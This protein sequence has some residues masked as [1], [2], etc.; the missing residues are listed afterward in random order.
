M[1]IAL[2]HVVLEVRDAE[3]TAA[4][5]ADLL[6]LAPVRMD[7]WRRGEAPFPSGRVTDETIIDYFPPAMWRNRRRAAN[8]NHLCFTL[9]RQGV[10]AL[11][12]KLARR[13]IPIQRESKR[14]YGAR[15]WG[16]SLYVEDPDGISVEARYYAARGKRAKA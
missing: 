1:N 10:A 2:D 7:E 12:R 14:N 11:R 8:P 16:V 6:G 9:S 3:A 4:F 13:G 15:G 5:Y